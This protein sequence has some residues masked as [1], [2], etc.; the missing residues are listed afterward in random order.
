MRNLF[1][2]VGL[3]HLRH[4]PA[5]TILTTLGVALGVALYVGIDII[6]RSTLTS[7]RESV[8][9]VAGKATLTVS[10]GET[11]F[12]ESRVPEIKKVPGVRHAV[13]MI[14]SRAYFAGDR[15]RHE[16]VVVLGVDLLQESA[17]RT[18]KT[19]DEEVIDDPLVF[20]NQPDSII[21]THAFAR[22]HGL[23]LDDRFELATARGPRKFTVRG[24]LSP[25]GPAKAFGGAVAIMDIDGARVTF[26]KEEKVDRVDIVTAPGEKAET[27]AGRLRERLGPGYVVERPESQSEGMERMVSSFQTMMRFFSSLALLVGIFLVANSVSIAVAER[28][29]E[30]G[31]LRS[32]GATRR[33][34]LVLFLSEAVVM[35][36]VGAFAGAWMGRGLASVLVNMVTRAMSS[37]YLTKIEVS[38]LEFGPAQVAAAIGLGAAAGFVAALW[39][40]LRA[41]SI[42]PLEA[43]R[44]QEVGEEAS[45][46]GFFRYGP[47]LGAVM[48]AYVVVSSVLL[49]RSVHPV[50]D[51]LGQI[52]SMLGSALVAPALVAWLLRLVRPLTAVSGDTVLRLAQD[53]LLRNPRRTG[54]NV[55]SLM[56]GLILVIMIGTVNTSFQDT[57]LRW[58]TKI[59]QADL[60]VSSNGR[61]ISYQVQ[62]VHEDIGREL[63]AVPGVRRGPDGNGAYALRFVHFRYEDRQLA[64]KAYDEPAPDVAY[65][66]FDVRDRLEAEAGRALFHS[67]GPST[68]VSENFVLHFGKK[69][70]DTIDVDTPSGRVRLRIVGVVTDF[71]SSVGV[72]YLDRRLYRR[73]WR[74]PLVSAFAIRVAPGSSV[75]DVRAEIDARVGKGRN[76][77]AVSNAELRTDMIRIIDQSFGYTRAIEG[78]ALLV[79]LLGLLNTLLISVMERTRELGMLRAVGMDRGQVTRLILQEAVFQGGLGAVVAVALG[80][81]I[82][83]FWVTC[84]LAHVLGWMIEFHFPW[85]SVAGTVVIGLA[86]A[87]V[88]GLYPSRRAANIEIR[89]A[90]EY[91]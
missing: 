39:P 58:F 17:V 12:P 71:A 66:T 65:S 69:T 30:I 37:Q 20:L 11:G 34:I 36:A 74:D 10:A 75:G 44:R 40:A 79:G 67:D 9:A 90:L 7:F 49:L 73:L 77:M 51:V 16:T 6:N 76:L 18:Y 15:T 4:K 22:A 21:V 45:R 62:P 88:A 1:Q 60:L 26:G 78:A 41:A 46:Q 82:A 25:E 55:M 31:T 35:G 68:M 64:I 5:R 63:S 43:M 42:Q 91:E 38:R 13:P 81:A 61:L 28:K 50:F 84:S 53:N 19:A 52:S 27:V 47:Y 85:A 2:F 56:V 29:R 87:L 83:Y 89:E 8:E 23:E 54:S 57:V 32:L 3:R 70:G 33:G 14:E 48:L 86:V 59:L 72:L 24:M 80:G